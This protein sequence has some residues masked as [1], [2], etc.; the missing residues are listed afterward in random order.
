VRL[1]AEQEEPPRILV[2]HDERIAVQAEARVE[3]A[4]HF[5]GRARHGG[6]DHRVPRHTPAPIPVLDFDLVIVDGPDPD[7]GVRGQLCAA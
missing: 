1:A 2:F 5:E 3:L 7:A 6:R 4:E